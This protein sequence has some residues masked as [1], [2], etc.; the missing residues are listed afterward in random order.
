MTILVGTILEW[1]D[2]S[3]LAAM[4][5]MIALLFFPSSNPAASLLATYSVMAAGFLVR[6]LGGV[7]FGHLGDRYGRTIAFSISILLMTIPTTLI[8]LL[9]TYQQFGFA[10]PVL[11]TLFRFIQGVASSGEYPGAMCYLTEIAPMNRKARWGGFSMFGVVGGILL[12]T[13]INAILSSVLTPEEMLSW[14]W[15]IP[16]LLGLPLGLLGW[17]LRYAMIDSRLFDTVKNTNQVLTFPLRHLIQHHLDDLVMAIIL[18]SLGSIVFYLGFVYVP[19]Y[20]VSIHQL[21][22]RDS[23][24]STTLST[25]IMF[26]CIPFFG[27]ISDRLNYLNV[28][29]VGSIFYV[30]GF[31]PLYH[32]M[33]MP[34]LFLTGQMILSVIASL[35][36]GVIVATIS[37]LFTTNMRFTGMALALNIGSGV[38][39]TLTPMMAAFL[40]KHYNN[41]ILP[42][43]YPILVATL[44]VL[45]VLILKYRK[46]EP[47]HELLFE[48]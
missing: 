38:L 21:S 6:P 41:P 48:V 47:N 20:L 23:L 4:A 39:G 14:G 22:L 8:G 45:V 5:P 27:Y 24:W 44:N 9:P 35:L 30:I 36:T 15:R 2:F 1:Y 31:Y 7:I 46:K 28:I 10:A 26:L 17:Y 34:G 18:F 16:F 29:L 3:L 11:L 42:A 37:N 32:M 40:V 19:S 25:S 43:F 12:G 33:L 13:L